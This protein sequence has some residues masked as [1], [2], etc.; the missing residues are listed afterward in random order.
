VKKRGIVPDWIPGYEGKWLPVDII[1]GLTVAA[2]VVPEGMAYAQLAGVPPEAAFYAAPIGL[3]LY[4]LFGSSRQL[5]VAVSGA[6]AV[7]S[8]SIVGQMADAG[9]EEFITLSAA[10]AIAAGVVSMLSGWLKLGRIAQFFSESVLTGFI[11]GLAL[12]IMIKQV[13]KIFGI[14][15]EEGNFFERLWNIVQNIGE[16]HGTSV[17]VGI[18]TLVLMLLL[19]R[20][21]ERIPA[22]LVALVGGILAGNILNLADEGVEVLGEVPSGLAGPAIPDIAAGDIGMLIVG[23]M[24]IT[25]V[26]F[27]EAVGPARDFASKH[28]YEIDENQE[29]VG[30]GAANMG[31]GLFQGFPIGSSLSKS[32]A[33]ERAGAKSPLSLV[34]AAIATALVALF[35]TGTLENLPEPTLGAIVIV[36][37]SGMLK[38]PQMKRLWRINRRDFL[39]AATALMG[40]LV[41]DTLPGLAMAVLLSLGAVIWRAATPR[42]SALGRKPGAFEFV[43]IEQ[44]PDARTITGMLLLRVEENLFFANA[45]S[46]RSGVKELAAASDPAPATLLMD[47]GAT[48][49]IDVPGCDELRELARELKDDG[50]TPALSHVRSPVLDMLERTGVVE[51]VGRE[52]IHATYV[53]A[54]AAHAIRTGDTLHPDAVTAEVAAGLVELANLASDEEVAQRLRRAIEVLEPGDDG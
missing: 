11:F 32:A 14:E 54:V 30:I 42:L 29:L 17:V 9:S 23:G 38:V 50:I 1:A 26:A 53:G 47:L 33:N 3:I 48:V 49:D 15:S 4:A 41:F 19:E 39:F 10:L 28:G 6:I 25:L 8:A 5:V 34:I 46:I 2:L 24:A 52:E 36:A 18:T 22:A 51:V 45:A 40:V 43:S 27:A 16:A 31:A 35:F 12:V 13:P 20:Y 37:V 21:F 44:H 7:L